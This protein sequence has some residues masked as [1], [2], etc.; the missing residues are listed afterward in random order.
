MLYLVFVFYRYSISVFHAI[1]G[2]HA[3]LGW[4]HTCNVTAYRNTVSWK[5]GRDSWSRNVSKVGYALTLW[6]CSLC[7]RN[8]IIHLMRRPNT[9]STQN[10][11]VTLPRNQLL[12]SYAVTSPVHTVMIRC[13]DTR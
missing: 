10:K 7:C 1:G 9:D 4:V 6:A 3:E 5:C 8:S 12:I 2:N 13:Y 11:P